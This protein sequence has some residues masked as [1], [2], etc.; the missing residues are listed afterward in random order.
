MK[1]ILATF[2]DRLRALRIEKNLTQEELGKT[3]LH[4]SDRM[5]RYYEQGQ[6]MPDLN[7]IVALA[8][9]F[10]VSVDYLLGRTDERNIKGAD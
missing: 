5:M 2:S 1:I 3:A 4:V 7:G 6:K 9:F 10:G 8:D